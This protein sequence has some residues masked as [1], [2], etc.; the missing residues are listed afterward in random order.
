MLLVDSMA[1][2]ATKVPWPRWGCVSAS[3][4]LLNQFDSAVSWGALSRIFAAMTM[5]VL[6]PFFAELLSRR[7]LRRKK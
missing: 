3:L 1:R 2:V 6:L 5:L 7:Y 4:L